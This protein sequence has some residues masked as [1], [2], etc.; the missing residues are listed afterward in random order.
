MVIKRGD[1]L[2]EVALA[3][4]IFSM[5]AIAVVSVVSGSTSSAQSALELTITREEIDAQAEAIR[6]IHTSYIAGGRSNASGNDKYE[7]LWNNIVSKAIDP[8]DPN[9]QQI[10]EAVLS[11]N[12]SECQSIYN[13][14]DNDITLSEQGAFVINTRNL[15]QTYNNNFTAIEKTAFFDSIILRPTAE[16]NVFQTTTTYP[17]MVYGGLESSDESIYDR[18]A[19]N[20]LK[21]AEGI[22]VIAI[23]DSGNTSVV[24]TS[25]GTTSAKA[26]SAYYDFYIRTCWFSAGAS[27]PSTVSTVIRLQDPNITGIDAVTNINST[28][29]SGN[30]SNSTPAIDNASN[31]TVKPEARVILNGNG[32]NGSTTVLVIDKNDNGEPLKVK[33]RINLSKY[34]DTFQWNLAGIEGCTNENLP[35]LVGWGNQ[36]INKVDYDTTSI[37]R[38]NEAGDKNLYAAWDYSNA[39][40]IWFDVNASNIFDSSHDNTGGQTVGFDVSVLINGVRDSYTSRTDYYK[41]VPIGSTLTV[42]LYGN[43]GAY[44][45]NFSETDPNYVCKNVEGCVVTEEPNSSTGAINYRVTLKILP[46]FLRAELDSSGHHSIRVTPIWACTNGTKSCFN[47]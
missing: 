5:V 8:S 3:I 26:T 47:V 35:K 21:S 46:Q 39:C 44:I 25:N 17:R 22:F 42:I 19:D 2:I 23:K 16:N 18:N 9:Q 28:P 24:N 15:G 31:V 38:V 27:R 43:K 10:A 30:S 11:Y 6:F 20:A 41:I 34:K 14:G 36:N 45:S 1:T 32:N 7:K 4:G 40:S 29:D 12:P 13:D 37:Y 33:D